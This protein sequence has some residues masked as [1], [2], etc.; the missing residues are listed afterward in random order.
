M[1]EIDLRYRVSGIRE[2]SRRLRGYHGETGLAVAGEC[3]SSWSATIETKIKRR[4][5]SLDFGAV[6]FFVASVK[7][8]WKKDVPGGRSLLP[9]DFENL[10]R[11][12]REKL[13]HSLQRKSLSVI[14]LIPTLFVFGL[15]IG[16][17]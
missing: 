17:A 16:P 14:P 11:I 4:I 13:A 12:W 6:A 1:A 8:K 15:R 2:G 10:L 5:V 9:T 3:C 7:L